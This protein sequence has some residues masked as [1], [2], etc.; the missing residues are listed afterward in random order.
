LPRH[1]GDACI[2]DEQIDGLVSELPA[3]AVHAFGIGHIHSQHGELAAGA[4]RQ[5][6]KLLRCIG[7]AARG[8]DLPPSGGVLAREFETNSAISTRDQDRWHLR[9]RRLLKSIDPCMIGGDDAL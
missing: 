1:P 6:R 5:G 4:L 9:C 3:S 8:K 2:I 7:I